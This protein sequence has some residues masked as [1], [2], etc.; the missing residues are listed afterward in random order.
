MAS[1]KDHLSGKQ[2][3]R[4]EILAREYRAQGQGKATAIGHARSAILLEGGTTRK[5]HPKKTHAR[6]VHDQPK[7][8]RKRKRIHATGSLRREDIGRDH[9]V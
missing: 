7:A 2:E 8:R 3:R 5:K 9:N 6:H 1:V 4:A